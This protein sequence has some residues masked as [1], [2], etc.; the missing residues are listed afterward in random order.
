M[1]TPQRERQHGSTTCVSCMTWEWYQKRIAEFFRRVDGARVRENVHV[2]GKSGVKRQ[3]DV[4]ILLP[5]EVRLGRLI[6]VKVDIH[7]IVDAKKHKRPVDIGIVGQIEDVRDDVGA[8][9]AIIASP[10]GFTKGALKRAPNV[11]VTP[12]V[13]TSDLLAMLEDLEIPWVHQCH[14]YL[15]DEGRGY[16]NW[17]PPRYEGQTILGS[18]QYCDVLHL[19]CPDCG[20]VFPIHEF[21]EG[22]PLR[23]PGCIRVY[24]AA[25]DWDHQASVEVRDELQVLLM[26]AAYENKSKRITAGKVSKVIGRTKWQYV[27]DPLIHITESELMEWTGDGE[28]L[29]L[30]EAGQQ[31]YEEFVQPAEDA[32]E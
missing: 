5:M 28:Y 21:D 32:C 23:C 31:D 11:N 7:I 22:K 25:R 18:C 1:T 17:R 30:T 10:I 13:M 19:L 9:L 29:R 4:L 2:N 3:L 8:H 15:C 16:I 20:S 14:N 6:T 12:L 27:E 24:R 26:T